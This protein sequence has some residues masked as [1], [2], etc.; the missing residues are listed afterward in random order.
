MAVLFVSEDT[1]KKS[2]TI[3][4]N[5]DVEL[6][7]P[8]IKVAQDIHI[9]Q[10]L[11]TDL[12]D[13]I[14]ADITGGTLTGNYQSFTD[15]YIQPVLIHYALFECLPFL[16]YKIM[17][18]DIVRKISETS[19]P[20]SLEDIKY[21]REIVKNT[22]EYYAT[23]L[24]DYLCNNNELFPE[25]TTNSNGDLAPTKDTYFSGIVLDKYEQNNRI[26]LRSFLDASYDI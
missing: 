7:L 23:R 17:N 25:Y 16:S 20:A 10:L 9:H 18:K 13:K 2:T 21:M 1:I 3:N 24:V 12:Y 4:G 8:Y 5:V 19:T 14:Q 15:D 22:A 11:G 26:T 6:L